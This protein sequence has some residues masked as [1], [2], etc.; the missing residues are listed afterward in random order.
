MSSGVAQYTTPIPIRSALIKNPP[1]AIPQVEE[2]EALQAELKLLRTRTLERA[3]KAG[4]DLKAIEESMR[5]LKD[6]EKGKGKAVEKVKRERGRA[7]SSSLSALLR[8]DILRCHPS[9]DLCT[10]MPLVATAHAMAKIA[11][12]PARTLS[13]HCVRV[14]APNVYCHPLDWCFGPRDAAYCGR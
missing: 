7:C 6:K 4:E 9:L 10:V 2:L 14:Y 13:S 11:N 3:K 12:P 1:D 5:R 8:A